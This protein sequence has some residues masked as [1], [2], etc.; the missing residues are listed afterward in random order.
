MKLLLLTLLGAVQGFSVFE[1]K[2]PIVSIK[3]GK[4]W[5]IDGHFKLVHVI[6]LEQFEH[7]LQTLN[8]AANEGVKEPEGKNIIEFHV[9]Q[10]KDRIGLLQGRARQARSIDW[11]GSAWKWI[12]GNPDAAD[13]NTILQSEQQIVE[14]N[15]HQYKINDKLFGIIQ[16]ITKKT[17]W[18][19]DQFKNE[20]RASNVGKQMQD[21]LNKILVVKEEVNEIVR[22]CQMARNGLVNTNLLDRE[23]INRIISE[24]ETLPYT[25]EIEA[26]EYGT[27]SIYTNGSILLYILAMPKVRNEEF[28]LLLTRPSIINGS[29][30]DLGFR[31]MLV[32]YRETFGILGNCLS[33]SNLTVCEENALKKLNEE[34]CVVRL[35]KGGHA[36]CTFQTNN[37][38]VIDLIKE[39]TIFVT[40][41]DG[42]LVSGNAS[43]SL[44][45]TYIIQL[46]NETIQLNN[47]TFS[48]FTTTNLQALPPALKNITNRVQKV[49]LEY[50][51]GISIG[52]IERLGDLTHK[53]TISSITDALIFILVVS[54]AWIIWRRMNQSLNIPP[55]VVPP[56]RKDIETSG[57]QAQPCELHPR[58]PRRYTSDSDVTLD[59]RDV[60]L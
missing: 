43:K 23:E 26:I 57:I 60:D 9:R 44:K 33:I 41:F 17:N 5:I 10:I 6:N 37:R 46:N 39:D 3:E 53:F 7:L 45:G 55:I 25:N 14:N 22:A 1:Y 27:P 32:N 47:R 30:L 21:I 4:G 58:L 38:E 34:D 31:R 56:V 59:L 12:A 13:W 18:I 36:A 24:I 48:S 40:N 54:V 29:Q 51:H 49:D 35:L 28:N 19:I 11:I 42:Q 8:K 16:D 20:V 52:N 50:V 15:N 2:E